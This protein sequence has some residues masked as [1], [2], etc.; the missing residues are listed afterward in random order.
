MHVL[1]TG[2][3]G[4]LGTDVVAALLTR[5][6]T[7]EA[8]SHVELD[9]TDPGAVSA[10]LIEPSFRFDACINCAAYTAVDRAETETDIATAVNSLAPAYLSRACALSSTQFLHIS[11]DFVFDGTKGEPYVETDPVNPLSVYGQT[12]LEGEEEALAGNQQAVVLRTAWLFGP[13]GKSFARTMVMAAREGRALRVVAD[14]TGSPTYSPDLAEIIVDCL[15]AK[16]PGGIYH[17]AGPDV[18]TW[19]GLAVA[20]IQADRRLRGDDHPVV[21][22]AIKTSDWPTPARRPTYSALSSEKLRFAG[23]PLVPPIALAIADF[24][25]RLG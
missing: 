18:M 22:E 9:A 4:M 6:H 25:S 1:V 8:P 14:Q 10:H 20:V 15:E 5:G 11:T 7:V 19:H 23:I 17:A 16:L 13:H 3:S 24:V 12:K 2:G 21:V